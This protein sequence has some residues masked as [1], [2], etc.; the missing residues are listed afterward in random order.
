MELSKRTFTLLILGT[1]FLLLYVHEQTSIFQVSYSIERKEREVARLS[2]DYKTAKFYLARL[3]SP[4][5]LSQRMKELSFTLT[6]PKD[7][8]MVKILKPKSLPVQRE[9]TWPAPFQFLSLL[10]FVKE[11][12]A[13]TSKG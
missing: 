12:Q 10:H 8:E 3:R 5:I 13:K 2:E 11:A 4:H 6:I 7:Q 9:V 1:L